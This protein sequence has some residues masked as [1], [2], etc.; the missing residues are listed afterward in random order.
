MEDNCW[1]DQNSYRVVASIKKEHIVNEQELC[2]KVGKWNNSILWCTVEKTS[3]N[4]ILFSVVKFR[5]SSPPLFYVPTLIVLW[6]TEFPASITRKAASRFHGPFSEIMKGN[7]NISREISNL[8]RL[9]VTHLLFMDNCIKFYRRFALRNIDYKLINSRSKFYYR[10]WWWI[11]NTQKARL[12]QELSCAVE[13]LTSTALCPGTA[14]FTAHCR[15]C[16]A[17]CVPTCKFCPSPNYTSKNYREMGERKLAAWFRASCTAWPLKMGPLGCPETS[18]RN[19]HSALRKI[20]K[21]LRSQ[22]T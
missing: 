12:I 14:S 15:C 9:K 22:F 6:D 21:E 18:V 4:N 11:A 2:I 1:A 20:P 17:D 16:I 8:S 5:T 13:F 10:C 3:K 19:C 7:A